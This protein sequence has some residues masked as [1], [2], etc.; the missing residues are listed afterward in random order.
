MEVGQVGEAMA[1]AVVLVVRAQNTEAELV[2]ILHHSM[3]DAIA[4]D[5]LLSHRHA[6]HGPAQV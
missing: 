5:L 2:L 6:T 4:L 3:A 1:V